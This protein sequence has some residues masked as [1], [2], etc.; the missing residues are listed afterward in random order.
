MSMMKHAIFAA[1]LVG[2]AMLVSVGNP[3]SA[4]T[5]AP[6]VAQS[7]DAAAVQ[8]IRHDWSH[9]AD[10]LGGRHY[11]RPKNSPNNY[12]RRSFRYYGPSV[13][14]GLSVPGI[15]LGIGVPSP[16]Y[17]SYDYGWPYGYGHGYRRY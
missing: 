4:A 16:R 8:Q 13:G 3:V 5:I 10:R 11:W 9:R 1:S 14:F 6:A 2:G 17:H 15:S 12:D 7:P